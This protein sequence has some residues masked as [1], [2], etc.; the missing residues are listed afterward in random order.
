MVPHQTLY[1]L[2]INIV[3]GNSLSVFVFCNISRL[4]LHSTLSTWRE[5]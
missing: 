3:A 4:N 2:H 5:L 1:F